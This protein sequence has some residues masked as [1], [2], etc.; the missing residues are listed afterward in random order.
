MARRNKKNSKINQ[1]IRKYFDDDPFDV[2]VER[3]ESKTLSELSATLGIYDIEHN[4]TLMV[5]TLRMIWSEAESSMRHDILNFFESDGRVYKSPKPKKE[6]GFDREDKINA[7]LEELDVTQEEAVRLHEAYSH[8]RS[9]KITIEKMESSLKHIRFEMKKEKL[10]RELEGLF[11]LD[12]SFEFNASL[13]Y[14]LY[15]QSF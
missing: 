12:D 4:K 3:V 7:L 5:K 14:A 2:G 10:E 6:V 1:R 15:E 13:K 9:K 11:D 8:V